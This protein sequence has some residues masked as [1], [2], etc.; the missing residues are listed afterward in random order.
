MASRVIVSDL[1]LREFLATR[2]NFGLAP[3]WFRHTP[4]GGAPSS[5]P[6]TSGLDALELAEVTAYQLAAYFGA[7]NPP[8][9]TLPDSKTVIA[10]F[11]AYY[12]TAA[13][14]AWLDGDKAIREAQWRWFMADAME[15]TPA[16]IPI[17]GDQAGTGSGAP[18]GG[19][20]PPP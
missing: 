17:S 11:A 18:S 12:A 16:T 2:G 5:P 14:K 9:G 8:T 3:S 4:L 7:I 10:A 1:T 20:V 6:S 13:Y 15:A 19:Y